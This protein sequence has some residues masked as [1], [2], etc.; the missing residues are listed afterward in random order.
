MYRVLIVDDEDPVLESYEFLL[1]NNAPDFELVGKA[2]TGFDAMKL[3]HEL[4]PDVVFMD[5]N[6]PGIDGMQVI[7]NV[8]SQFPSTIFILSTAYERFDL[9]RKAISLGV[10]AYLVK[11][12]S[13]KTFLETL[14]LARVALEDYSVPVHN[15]TPVLTE[16][17]FVGEIIWNRIGEA[18]WLHYKALYSFESDKGIVCMIELENENLYDVIAEKISFRHR[19]LW[20]LRLGQAVF[21]IPEDTSRESFSSYIKDVIKDCVPA[22]VFCVSGVGEPHPSHEIYLSCNEALEDLR[23]KKNRADVQLRERLRIIQLRR[24]IGISP[25]N[26][27]TDVYNS[28]WEE[29]FSSH[30]FVLAKA[31]MASVFMF[32]IDDS[33]GA[34]S[35]HSEEFPPFHAVEEIMKIGNIDEWKKW[36]QVSFGK[37]MDI[38]SLRYSGK[39]P[40][41]LMNAME[42][43]HE[44]Y[45]EP[46]QLSSAAE[47]AKVSSTYLSRLFSEYIQCTFIDYVTALRIEE[48]EKLIREARM[49]IKEVAFAVGFQD[50]NYFSKIFRKITGLPPSLYAA[51][52]RTTE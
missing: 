36:S 26:E 20:T 47:A 38:C 24:K 3:I 35:R 28:L 52:K 48:A 42:Y 22:S 7:S 18:E 34:Y 16:E 25:K 49:N 6:I 8:S 29:I 10:F 1:K 15:E 5:I 23:K 43:V 44:H 33:I 30:D 32:L 37:M 31:K 50:A 40:L 41:P 39:F 9:A 14:A 27:V 11:P 12:V 21:F 2:S 19:C 45:A 51:E 13:K 46:I 4:K 17:Q